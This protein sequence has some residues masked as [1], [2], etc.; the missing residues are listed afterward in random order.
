MR[1]RACSAESE[2][3]WDRY[4]TKCFYCCVVA[5]EQEGSMEIVLYCESV[6][7]IE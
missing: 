7:H 4:G 1:E 5:M 3:K 6:F 2:K